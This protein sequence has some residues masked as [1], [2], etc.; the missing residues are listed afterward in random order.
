MELP[1]DDGGLD[2][3]DAPLLPDEGQEV[4]GLPY[5]DILGDVFGDH[6]AD[7]EWLE[8][9]LADISVEDSSDYYYGA[10]IPGLPADDNV[11]MDICEVC[12]TVVALPDNI[13]RFTCA[14]RHKCVEW[15]T[16]SRGYRHNVLMNGAVRTQAVIDAIKSSQGIPRS[17]L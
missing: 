16:D 3:G 5:D 17:E 7:Q 1:P 15:L 9:N 14:C 13:I 4:L 12:E 10:H 2:L 11:G 8:R 6:L